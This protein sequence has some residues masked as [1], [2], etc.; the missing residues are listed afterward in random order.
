M[1]LF[2]S[3]LILGCSDK[4]EGTTPEPLKWQIHFDHAITISDTTLMVQRS[5]AIYSNGDVHLTSET[6]GGGMGMQSVVC[7][8]DVDH[9]KVDSL[10]PDKQ[11][12]REFLDGR[13]ILP[14]GAGI[15]SSRYLDAKFKVELI[16]EESGLGFVLEG[17]PTWDE[18]LNE[19]EAAMR[20]PEEMRKLLAT[21]FIFS[22]YDSACPGQTH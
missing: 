19:S 12:I 6:W 18:I 4:G 2:V 13:Y 5:V 17:V 22:G 9:D 3:I 21:F 16:D 8:F 10:F 1:V 20:F 7:V 11:K 14:W 15:D